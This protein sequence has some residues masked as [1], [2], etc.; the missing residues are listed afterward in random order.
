MV[1]RRALQLIM[2]IA[3]ALAGAVQGGAG[4]AR[5]EED[6]TATGLQLLFCNTL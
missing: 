1:M 3:L 2:V 6:G 5:A 4:T